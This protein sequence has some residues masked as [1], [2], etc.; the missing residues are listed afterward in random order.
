M[1][2]ILMNFGPQTA[3]T[4]CMQRPWHTGRPSGCNYQNK[5]KHLKLKLKFETVFVLL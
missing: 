3:N 4:N 5:D 2:K 1:L